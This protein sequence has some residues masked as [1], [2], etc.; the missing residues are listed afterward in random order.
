[1]T[2]LLQKGNFQIATA[3]H[4]IP[5]AQAP[6]LFFLNVNLLKETPSLGESDGDRSI[7]TFP[8]GQGRWNQTSPFITAA[9]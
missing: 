2:E 8:Q 6:L 3:I 5:P 7:V 1:M 4:V 9:K